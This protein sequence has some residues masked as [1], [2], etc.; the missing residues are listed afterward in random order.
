M[1]GLGHSALLRTLPFRSL[2]RS[3]SLTLAQISPYGETSHIPETLY[4]IGFEGENFIFLYNSKSKN[5][6]GEELCQ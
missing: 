4:A 5:I 6:R 2:N 3:G 1:S